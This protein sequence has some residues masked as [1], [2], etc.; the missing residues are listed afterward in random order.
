MPSKE[1]FTGRRHSLAHAPDD[2]SEVCIHIF[3]LENLFQIGNIVA[4]ITLNITHKSRIATAFDDEPSTPSHLVERLLDG[5]HVDLRILTE[6]LSVSVT[7]MN[8]NDVLAPETFQFF[9][10]VAT[11]IGGHLEVEIDLDTLA[12]NFFEQAFVIR[13]IL[14]GPQPHGHS[15]IDG[16]L[17]DGAESTDHLVV[18]RTRC[19]PLLA[20]ASQGQESDLRTEDFHAL[21]AV[22]DKFQVILTRDQ[23][24]GEEPTHGNRRHLDAETVSGT[25]EKGGLFWIAKLILKEHTL[26][27]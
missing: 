19:L 27:Q 3:S 14:T 17:T 18:Q 26:A 2:A 23:I 5:R 7:G 8:L 22:A 9:T 4:E 25:A 12:L 6:I 10:D 15:L 1:A 21:K 24:L 16:Q 20:T 11:G 13:S